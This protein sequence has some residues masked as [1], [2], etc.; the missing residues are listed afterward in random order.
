MHTN[1][2]KFIA[3]AALT[4]VVACG[5]QQPTIPAPAQAKAEAKAKAAA[6]AEA[7]ERKR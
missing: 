6:E 7:R 2:G 1:L 5:Q 4:G 3:L